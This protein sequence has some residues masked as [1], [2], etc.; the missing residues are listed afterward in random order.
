MDYSELLIKRRSIRNF[1]DRPVPVDIIRDMI[2]ESTYAPTASNTQGWKFIIIN[3]QSVMK[4]ISDECK[5][6]LL[7]RMQDNPGD[8]AVRYEQLM[9]NKDYNI[10]YNAPCVVYILGEQNYKNLM[11]DSALAAGYFMFAA[12]SRGLGTCWINFAAVIQSTDMLHELGIPD[13]CRIVAP[14]I[15]GYPK[16]IPAMPARKEP[17][18]LKVI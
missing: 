4:R 15:V 8:Y 5:R 16:N 7:A 11:V 12:A 6:T 10:F 3:D 2:R 13:E 18:I 17:E 9:R 1:E 14:I